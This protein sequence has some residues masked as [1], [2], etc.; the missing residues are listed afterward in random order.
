MSRIL[1]YVDTYQTIMF[2]GNIYP[3]LPFTL[4]TESQALVEPFRAI[5]F[6]EGYF[7]DIWS[8]KLANEAFWQLIVDEF[9]NKISSN[10]S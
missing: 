3:H 2:N 4:S 8:V 1:G 7:G 10:P 6:Y 9:T 5:G